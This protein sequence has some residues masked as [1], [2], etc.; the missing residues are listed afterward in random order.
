MFEGIWY[1]RNK[2]GLLPNEQIKEDKFDVIWGNLKQGT[3]F[4]SKF[5]AMMPVTPY[6][7]VVV[8]YPDHNKVDDL[9]L[10]LPI[11]GY[12]AAKRTSR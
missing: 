1:F 2:D 7:I 11:R 8:S 5:L 12:V 6:Y 4:K 10:E 3:E 9:E